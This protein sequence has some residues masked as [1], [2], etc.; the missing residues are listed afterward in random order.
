M[1]IDLQKVHGEVDVTNFRELVSDYRFL[2]E[3]RRM[4][5]KKG[6]EKVVR[7][8]EE[9]RPPK[10]PRVPNGEES[11]DQD[12]LNLVWQMAYPFA[13]STVAL[14]I[15][16]DFTGYSMATNYGDA[17]D[18]ARGIV[19]GVYNSV[20]IRENV[21]HG[22]F[23]YRHD[24]DLPPGG[25]IL[26]KTHC[27]GHCMD[28]G[29]DDCK[30]KDYAIPLNDLRTFFT[31]CASGT[32]MTGG[33]TKLV[34]YDPWVVEK[35]MILARHP[36]EIIYSRFVNTFEGLSEPY[37]YMMNNVGI[38]QWCDVYDSQNGSKNLENWYQQDGLDLVNEGKV[39]CHE[40]LY[41][42]AKFYTQSFK[43]AETLE[44][45]YHVVHFED[46]EADEGAT[47]QGIMDFLEL[48]V[49]EN[50]R[51]EQ[52]FNRAGDNNVPF[53]TPAQVNDMLEFFRIHASGK[54]NR[55]FRDY[56]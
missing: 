49:Q 53:F 18:T 9:S 45:D 28:T 10:V 35:L 4:R 55:L 34:E 24:L 25:N 41:R 30:L 46:Y 15:V 47:I 38:A 23:K 40:E 5:A 56:V 14:T 2:L 32:S 31:S 29:A 1:I 22:P 26:V 3:A 37:P 52:A 20:P 51:Q 11:D 36:I 54:A 19:E 7:R 17:V 42:I 13:G 12:G 39:P 16:Q 43:V 6:S 8:A 33:R 50:A 21:P 44:D 27:A 48:R